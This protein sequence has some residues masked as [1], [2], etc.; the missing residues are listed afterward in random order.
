MHGN[1]CTKYVVYHFTPT[2]D[3]AEV[4]LYAASCYGLMEIDKLV[5]DLL[6]KIPTIIIRPLGGARS[7]L[8]YQQ[9][10]YSRKLLWD[11]SIET[12]V[13][14]TIRIHGKAIKVLPPDIPTF[15]GGRVL[16]KSDEGYPLITMK[17]LAIS[18]PFYP[19][20]FKIPLQDYINVFK[21]IGIEDINKVD[22]MEIVGNEKV[23]LGFNYYSNDVNIVCGNILVHDAIKVLDNKPITIIVS[24][25]ANGLT[26]ISSREVTVELNLSLLGVKGDKV[27][28]YEILPNG[29][30][31]TILETEWNEKIKLYIPSLGQYSLKM[32]MVKVVSS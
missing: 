8:P 9:K 15:V 26:I 4:A 16:L 27:V 19:I 5:G 32:I 25:E 13:K 17:Y 11:L 28:L 12:P 14:G 2:E 6:H 7:F 21:S 18:I 10:P 23:P 24:K 20:A 31:R 3:K 29:E 22:S 1:I 30:K